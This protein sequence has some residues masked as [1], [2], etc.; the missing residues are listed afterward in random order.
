MI[1]PS[2]RDP[3][4][5]SGGG[6]SEFLYDI[7]YL[8]AQMR[9]ADFERY[10]MRLDEEISMAMFTPLLL[11][12]AGD[13]GSL[14]L[15]V[16]HTLTWLWSLNA[17][18]FDAKDYID[19]YL[20]NRIKQF[21]FGDRAPKAFWIPRKMGKDNTETLRAIIVSMIAGGGAK[22][23]IEELGVALGMTVE[24]VEIITAPNASGIPGNNDSPIRD[25]SAG[26]GSNAN[27]P[28][29]TSRP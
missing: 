29:T 24:E 1:L 18:A 23:N 16:Q 8:E 15:G 17:L 2:D 9:G 10:L 19:H 28:R 21:N 22:V 4:A 25:Q 13:V 14:N 3:T 27:S 11:M 20:V 26:T 5:S 12:R 6:R 7:E